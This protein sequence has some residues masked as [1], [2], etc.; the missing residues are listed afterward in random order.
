[1]HDATDPARAP[2]GPAGAAAVV[3]D[4]VVIRYGETLAVDHLTFAGRAGQVVALLGPNGAGKTSTVEALEGYRPV[5]AGI[6]PGARPRP[7]PRPRRPGPP[8]S[9]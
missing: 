8:A 7:R 4:G 9:G 2:F 6:G 5:E 1:M 3:C